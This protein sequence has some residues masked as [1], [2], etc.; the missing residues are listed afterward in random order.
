VEE[1]CQILPPGH[2]PRE[3]C[4]QLVSSFADVSWKEMQAQVEKL[5]YLARARVPMGCLSHGED[6][7]ISQ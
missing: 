6:Q 7:Q 4:G 2:F 3:E 1:A 5:R